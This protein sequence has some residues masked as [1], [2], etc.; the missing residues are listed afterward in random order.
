MFCSRLLI[1]KTKV[2]STRTAQSRRMRID[3]VYL[4]ML[5]T[6]QES[7]S[8]AVSNVDLYT[9]L[10]LTRTSPRPLGLHANNLTVRDLFWPITLKQR[11]PQSFQGMSELRI[12]GYTPS[13]ILVK[14]LGFRLSVD[15]A[16]F[17]GIDQILKVLV[18]MSRLGEDPF[19]R[20]D[21]V[22]VEGH[23]VAFVALTDFAVDEGV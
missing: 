3:T 16:I 9:R 19:A 7:P 21:E 2:I 15:P 4:L 23:D 22:P 18:Y 20:Y 10:V 1:Q 13:L 14:P 17:W 6:V 11:M 8:Q 12:T 5:V